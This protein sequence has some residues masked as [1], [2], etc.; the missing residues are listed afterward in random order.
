MNRLRLLIADDERLVR[1]GI[2]RG[3]STL[4]GIEV[5]GEC[6]SG[7]ETI[8]AILT[9]QP[10]LVLL[11]VQLQDCTG[12]DVI[13]QIGPERMPLVVFVTAYD[14]YAVKAFEL[15]AVDYLLKPFEEERLC[16]S[17]Q[18]VRQRIEATSQSLLA[19]QLHNLLNS[20]R[21]PWVDRLV[22]R[23]GERFEMVPVDTID[24]I[25]SADNYVQLHCGAKQHT[26]GETLT[27]LAETLDPRKFIRVHRRRIVNLSR[28]VALYS[29]PGGT[30]DIEL[31]SGARLTTGRQYRAAI[32]TL[33]RNRT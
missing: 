21:Q 27:N 23:H 6:A 24:W 4:G 14:E 5:V 31:R 16:Q 7:K 28:I 2:R 33:L 3:L 11:D 29:M 22:V 12:L 20:Q 19:A 25:D 8:D 13:R 15:N 9:L 18:R 17:I 10:D 32:Q 30:W 26:L 1:D